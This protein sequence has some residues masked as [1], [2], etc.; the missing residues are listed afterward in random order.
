[1]FQKMVEGSRSVLGLFLIEL[2]CRDVSSI[3]EES[4]SIAFPQLLLSRDDVVLPEDSGGFQSNA[5]FP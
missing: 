5:C 3:A 2:L 4:E 1:M